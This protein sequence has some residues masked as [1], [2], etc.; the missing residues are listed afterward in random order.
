MLKCKFK[1]IKKKTYIFFNIVTW[2][3]E[4]FD[5][6]ADQSTAMLDESGV[7]RLMQKLNSNI[8]PTR[9]QQKVKVSLITMVLK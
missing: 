8:A 6:E 5:A 7:V 3:Q 4:M 1:Q 2:L 9:V